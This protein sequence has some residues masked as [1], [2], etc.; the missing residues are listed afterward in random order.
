MPPGDTSHR[1]FNRVIVCL[2]VLLSRWLLRLQERNN[3]GCYR[4][5]AENTG[6]C[7]MALHRQMHSPIKE[8]CCE[9]KGK[10]LTKRLANKSAP[11]CNF[12]AVP[13]MRTLLLRHQHDAL[14]TI[15]NDVLVLLQQ[16]GRRNR[17]LPMLMGDLLNQFDVL[18]W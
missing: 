5:T 10:Q 15:R 12:L 1:F 17:R 18:I 2:L 6:N 14:R 3:D 11:H 9:R 4:R 7:V 13:R 16:S 8:A